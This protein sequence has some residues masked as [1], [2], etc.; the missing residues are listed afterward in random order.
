M[1]QVHETDSSSGIPALSETSEYGYRSDTRT[2]IAADSVT[3]VNIRFL[4]PGTVLTV[5]TVNSSYRIVVLN[6]KTGLVTMQ[7]GE[8]FPQ[9]TDVRI[10]G[11]TAGGSELRVGW[12]ELGLRLEFFVWHRRIVTSPV[13]GITVEV[14]RP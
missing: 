1:N 3:D 6:G 9:P 5:D 13:R 11:S 2:E 14:F 8:L 10:E 7:G 12:I 4:L